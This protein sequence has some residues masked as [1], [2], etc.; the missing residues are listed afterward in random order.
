M[1]RQN[2]DAGRVD[3]QQLIKQSALVMRQTLTG[4]LTLTTEHPIY[5][6]LDPGGA[7]RVVLLPA[8][9][10]GLMYEVVNAADA[11]ELLTFKEDS[12]T[13]VV[14]QVAPGQSVSIWCDGVSWYSNAPDVRGAVAI[15]PTSD[16]L[17][18]GLIPS[19]ATWV[20]FTSANANNIATLPVGRPGQRIRGWI[21]ATGMEIRTPATSGVLIN[22]VDGDGSQEAAIPATTLVDL[23]YVDATVGWILICYTELGA[24]ITA[25]VPD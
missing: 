12:N 16:G 7:D 4:G 8:E 6:S 22:G 24:V 9:A 21:G 18:T 15:T 5:L 17:T 3:N 11:V 1:T 10:E 20:A 23:T 14:C 19:T 13:T 25:I 2:R